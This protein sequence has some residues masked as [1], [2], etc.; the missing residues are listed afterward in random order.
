[1]FT[2]H[3]WMLLNLYPLKEHQNLKILVIFILFDL[4]WHSEEI[5][6]VS[7]LCFCSFEFYR[8]AFKVLVAESA[9]LR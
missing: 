8:D 6:D 5:Q 2:S 9:L 7:H 4:M 3:F 1:M